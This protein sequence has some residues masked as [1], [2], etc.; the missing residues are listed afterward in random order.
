MRTERVLL[1]AVSAI[2]T[3]VPAFSD[4]TATSSYWDS[5]YADGGWAN[6][7]N[8]ETSTTT[9]NTTSVYS[10]F[11][12]TGIQTYPY[13]GATTTITGSTYT[14][15]PAPYSYTSDAQSVTNQIISNT[16][17]T[18]G[19]NWSQPSSSLYTSYSAY[20]LSS[21]TTATY[22]S[23]T[24]TTSYSNDF[25]TLDENGIPIPSMYT[26]LPRPVVTASTAPSPASPYQA[27][28]M[29]SFDNPEPGTSLLLGGGLAG[30]LLYTRKR[31][32]AR[33]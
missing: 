4:V 27:P 3:V 16:T 22:G 24:T 11:D 18:S 8:S 33:P 17:T 14:S 32:R 13:L 9:V 26:T 19:T 12:S 30:L 7:I 28:A 29:L 15:Y 10:G 2:V 21:V 23:S 25:V 31:L 6:A 20:N 5:L 1:V